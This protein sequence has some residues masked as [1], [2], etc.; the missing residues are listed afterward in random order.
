M[1]SRCFLQALKEPKLAGAISRACGNES[2]PHVKETT[3]WRVYLAHSMS[4]FLLSTSNKTWGALP[5]KNGK[6]T[7]AYAR[8]DLSTLLPLSKV[9]F[10][11]P[12]KPTP[13]RSTLTKRQA[14]FWRLL[15]DRHVLLTLS[16]SLT[17]FLVPLKNAKPRA[18]VV[19][20]AS[21]SIPASHSHD[22]A[23]AMTVQSSS[24]P[25]SNCH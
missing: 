11:L 14:K 7:S 19:K 4:H 20:L 9:H 21:G 8:P 16:D 3:S 10:W 6:K 1:P 24:S 15:F 18:K 5:E 23:R 13:E 25:N 22:D 17:P 12:F 2:S